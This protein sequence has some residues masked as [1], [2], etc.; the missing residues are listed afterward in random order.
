MTGGSSSESSDPGYESD[1]ANLNFRK[2]Q[3]QFLLKQT[4]LVNS[5]RN[6]NN[7][8]LFTSQH[9][10]KIE[11]LK[12]GASL[13]EENNNTSGKPSMI[14]PVFSPILVSNS[15]KYSA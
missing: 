7:R 12:N 13:G 6:N 4:I 14:L 15:D 2:L 5:N 11:S 8:D 10:R 9:A 3:Q 1:P